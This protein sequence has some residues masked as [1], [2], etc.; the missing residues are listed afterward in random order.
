MFSGSGLETV[1]FHRY[2][3]SLVT[4]WCVS[5]DGVRTSQEGI[6][7]SHLETAGMTLSL[8]VVA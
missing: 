3:L 6:F 4:E 1:T 8:M 7:A 2:P 5:Y